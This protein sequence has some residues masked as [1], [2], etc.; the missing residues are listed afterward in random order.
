MLLNDDLAVFIVRTDASLRLS[1][2]TWLF[3]I[4][5]GELPPPAMLRRKIIIKNKKKHHHHHHHKKGSASDEGDSSDTPAH[6]GNGDIGT[7]HAQ[8]CY[9]YTAV[10]E[11]FLRVRGT[12]QHEWGGRWQWA[13][14]NNKIRQ[15]VDHSLCNP[16]ICF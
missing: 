8:V 12:I 2:N 3:V 5:G 10:Y 13:C 7:Q 1:C 15:S 11:L 16:V 14:V 9:K 6:P 4:P